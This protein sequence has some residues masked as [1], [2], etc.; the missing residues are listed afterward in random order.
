MT[1][2]KS[3]APPPSAGPFRYLGKPS[4]SKEAPRLVR[5][6][7]QYVDDIQMPGLLHAAILRSPH[8]HARIVRVEVDPSPEAPQAVAVLT[9]DDVQRMGHPF[10]L[11]RYAAGL[12]TPVQEY[13]TAVGKVRYVGEPVA[14]VA[15]RDRAGAEDALDLLTVEYD[16][17]PAVVSTE[18]ALKPESALLYD[19]L[20]SNIAWQ[21]VVA[22]G[23]VE[24]AFRDAE[25]V[26]RERLLLHRYS[27]TP[28][29]TF[30]CIA[31]YQPAGPRLV[32]W[33][34][35]Q[36]PEVVYDALREA[37]GIDDVR[38][39]IPDVGGGF[40]QKIHLIR[41]YAVITSLLSMKSGRPVKWTED[42]LEHM[43]AA[44][45]SCEQELHVEAAVRRDGT[46]QGMRIKSIE[47]VGGSLSTATIHFS[48][49]LNNL[50]NTYKTQHLSLEGVAVTTN[51]CPVVPNRGIGK[52]AMCFVWERTMDRIAEELGLDR[53][54]VRL[55][56]V[57]RRDQ[58]PYQAPN[59]NI[60]DSGDYEGLLERATA[61]IGY[62]G[63]KEEQERARKEGR[64][65]GLGLALGIEPG[66][67]N[68]ARQAVILPPGT[69]TPLSGGTSGATIKLERGGAITLTLG[70]MS[71]G[72]SHETIASQIVAEVLGVL[73][74]QVNVV[75]GFDTSTSPW[76]SASVNS[77]NNFH[78]YDVGAIHGATAKLREKLLA[79]AGHLLNTDP[80][81]LMVEG[82]TVRLKEGPATELG[83][84]DLARV[85]YGH[86]ALLPEGMEPGL[87]AT[88]MY[89]F[90]HAQPFA[91]PD[92][93]RRVRAQ[94]TFPAAVHAAVVEVD[95]ETG[96][97]SVRRYVIVSDNGTI[98]NPPVV[99][100]QIYGSAAHGI[101]VALGEGFVYD[102]D[103][104]L[105]T[106]TLT[107][108]GKSTTCDTPA[109][110]IEHHPVPSPF[111]TFGQKA[112]G[113]GAAIPSPAA[114]ASAVEDALRPLGVR[115]RELPLGLEAVWRLARQ[116]APDKEAQDPAS[117]KGDR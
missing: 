18:G 117:L 61:R 44:G 9:P 6:H 82:D 32:V 20:G 84:A 28:L 72:Q 35:A 41:K 3:Q 56:N 62:E 71:C 10:A 73:P 111:T 19:E 85:A 60:Y 93:L 97:V 98:L 113:E 7:G 92:E 104:Q 25:L 23:D 95:R 103:G 94:Y 47:D 46:V 90:P 45:H 59:G 87:Q 39:I 96:R 30:A 49:K 51:K 29:E 26:V 48:N 58:F 22:Y 16:P 83:L 54:E 11:G 99:D 112:V 65:L 91:V 1:T 21:G 5:G 53:V 101:S 63:F 2:K 64:L 114:I 102:S 36:A 13:A 31:S 68:L 110:E 27:S 12:R 80:D 67:R 88:H 17:L 8:A 74:G 115:V 50:F 34:N 33:C 86:Q 69:P 66:G 106:V 42:R 109:I 14:A 57:V 52:P 55:R 81:S 108:Y 4:P 77:S 15:A 79:L 75:P 89:Q 116:A 107:D 78:L 43:M 70:T 100:G 40:G 24:G 76:G 37:L 105:L 38:L